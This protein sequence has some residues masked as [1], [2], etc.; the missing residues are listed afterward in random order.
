MAQLEYYVNQYDEEISSFIK[1][2]DALSSASGSEKRQQIQSCQG[3]EKRIADL[4]QNVRMELRLLESAEK[5]RWRGRLDEMERS[6]KDGS[7]ELKRIRQEGK[8]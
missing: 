4:K 3:M 7:E 6:F 2:V 5:A 8:E 1:S